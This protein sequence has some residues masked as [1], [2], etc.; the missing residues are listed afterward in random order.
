MPADHTGLAA[1]LW[2]LTA[3]VLVAAALLLP[4]RPA[5]GQDILEDTNNEFT[6]SYLLTLSGQ[7]GKK[8]FQGVRAA[9]VVAASPPGSMHNYVITVNGW[10]LTNGPSTFDWNSEDSRLESVSGRVTCRIVNSFSRSPN[11]HFFYMSPVLFEREGM[12]TQHEGALL[13][14]ERREVQP[15][16]IQA[17]AGE[18]TLNF[19]G[20]QVTGEVWMNGY[21]PVQK[22]HVRYQATIQG[23][24]S[25][26]LKSTLQGGRFD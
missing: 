24:L 10:P 16:M 20:R 26:D 22:S 8:R 21:D 4:A 17:V 25:R 11:I 14:Q 9:L 18:L 13:A 1:R 2:R 15:T 19:N 3:T 5:P 12:P 23:E 7:V 6:K